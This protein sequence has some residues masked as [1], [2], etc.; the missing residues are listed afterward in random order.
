MFSIVRAIRD[1]NAGSIPGR[2]AGVDDPGADGTADGEEGTAVS[3]GAEGAEGPE[4]G[5]AGGRWG[6]WSFPLRP[7][8]AER[9]SNTAQI[10][11]FI[12]HVRM[13][14]TSH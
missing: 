8:P 4:E 1:S 12:L 7:H 9:S 11:K 3:V 6:L 5:E 10:I 14:A 13:A 2:S